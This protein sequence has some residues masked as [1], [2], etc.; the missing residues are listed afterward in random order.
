MVLYDLRKR[1]GVNLR[2]VLQHQ[3]AVSVTP[4]RFDPLSRL[5][6]PALIMH[7]TEDD[8]IPVE[9][10]KK[11]ATVIPGARTIWLEGV[12]HV[13]PPPG[14]PELTVEIIAHIEAS[15]SLPLT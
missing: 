5:N 15:A 12:G 6:V 2:A 11:L 9:H 8:I 3:A 7:G 13:F 1:C 14:L 10:V 4:P